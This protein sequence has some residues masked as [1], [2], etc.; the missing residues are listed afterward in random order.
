VSARDAVIV[1][2][3]ISEQGRR[4]EGVDSLDV[5]WQAASRAIEDAGIDKNEIDGVSGVWTGPGGTR[6]DPG[7]PDWAQL[8]GVRL[9]WMSDSYPQ[10]VPALAAA[11][12]AIEGSLCDSVLIVNG[13]AGAFAASAGGIAPW[14]RPANEFIEPYG[15]TTPGLFALIVA[16]YQYEYGLDERDLAFVSAAIR[17]HGSNT[18]GAVMHGRGPYT[19]D[20]ILESPYIAE[21]LRLLNICLANE[22][23]AAMIVTTR[24]RAVD[25]PKPP[26]EILG[27]GMEWRRQQYVNPP[28]FAESHL[29][30]Q[31][32]ADR[33]FAQAG[34]G[35]EEIDVFHLHDANAFEIV[36]QM[37]ALRY[38]EPG[39]GAA[40]L[41]ERGIGVEGMAI[42]LNGG[43]LA[44]SHPGYAAP[45]L[46]TAAA[47]RQ[48]RGEAEAN[49]VSGARTAL[50]SG[51][52]SA[53]QY[54]NCAILGRAA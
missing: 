54:Y 53:A 26:I 15:S 5:K 3:G 29:L 4:L 36:R 33:A 11:K 17:N 48:L 14:T 46:I 43:L 30:G 52:G 42:N 24:E 16:R 7:S 40:F 49:Q 41:R 38:A 28:V 8:L 6:F 23:A 37:E 2:V 21:P 9:H 25:L 50:I 12:T 20:D 22:G 45:T 39:T 18:P 32:A 34:I 35:R 1:G 13:Q 31:E 19:E 44:F 47:V 51:A 10:G 27:I